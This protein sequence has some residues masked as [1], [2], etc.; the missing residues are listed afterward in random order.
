MNEPAVHG[1]VTLGDEVADALGA[2]QAVVALESTIIAHGMPYPRN[3]E[4]AERVEAVIRSEG[5]VPA[6]VA[7]IDGRIVVGLDGD[8]LHLIATDPGVAKLSLRDLGWALA[9]SAL[10]ATTVATTMHAARLAGIRVFATGGLGGVHRGEAGDVSA[11]LTALA[12]I[13]VGVVSAGVKAILDI[14]RTLEA[15]ETRGVPVIGYQTSTFPEFYNRGL[16]HPVTASAADPVAVAAILQAHWGVGATTGAVIAVP[17]PAEHEAD[18]AVIHEAIEAGL[19]AAERRRV[20]GK[21]ITPFLLDFVAAHT[22]GASLDANVELVA[23]NAA[24]AARV[25]VELSRGR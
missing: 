18:R 15:L 5:A 9:G 22:G 19:F 16:E 13:P 3:L 7:V 17:I 2:G 23:H 4:T 11:D 25:A 10:G 1:Y 24:V 21:D 8:Q 20:S 6:T 14:P 12:T